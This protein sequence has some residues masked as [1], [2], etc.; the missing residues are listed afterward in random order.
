MAAR[1][2]RVA[3]PPATATA[4]G[5]EGTWT[6]SCPGPR[7]WASPAAVS[8]TVATKC[9]AP[10]AWAPPS[11]KS[12][13]RAPEIVALPRPGAPRRGQGDRHGEHRGAARLG[14]PTADSPRALRRTRVALPRLARCPP[15]PAPATASSPAAP[16]AWQAGRG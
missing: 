12:A 1:S 3:E 13:R 6:A 9:R 10:P 7:A 15:R 11:R 5:G 8:C 4:E 14:G 2:T 16:A